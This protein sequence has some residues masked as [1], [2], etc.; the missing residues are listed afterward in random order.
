MSHSNLR[1]RIEMRVVHAIKAPLTFFR[2]SSRGLVFRSGRERGPPEVPSVVFSLPPCDLLIPAGFDEVSPAIASWSNTACTR[3]HRFTICL[4]VSY[5]SQEFSW[6]I[7]IWKHSSACINVGH[8]VDHL[9]IS[10]TTFFP[11]LF[12]LK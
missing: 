5:F 3:W 8:V 2:R 7:T 11:E 6:K 12:R 1:F 4:K 10:D 9:I